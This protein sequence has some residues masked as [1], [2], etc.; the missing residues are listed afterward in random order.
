MLRLHCVEADK[1]FQ[2]MVAYIK[3]SCGIGRAMPQDLLRVLGR[4]L[5]LGSCKSTCGYGPQCYIASYPSER[6]CKK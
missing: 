3:D 5:G 6:S 1:R 4:N 2:E